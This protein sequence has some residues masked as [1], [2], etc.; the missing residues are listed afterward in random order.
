ML[1]CRII[2]GRRLVHSPCLSFRSVFLLLWRLTKQ[3][4]VGISGSG[5]CLARQLYCQAG[6]WSD[7]FLLCVSFAMLPGKFFVGQLL[8]AV[9]T[10]QSAAFPSGSDNPNR[11]VTLSPLFYDELDFWRW[12]VDKGFTTMVLCQIGFS[13]VWKCGRIRCM[14][15]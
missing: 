10:P 9:G 15:L 2:I 5:P 12:L 6:V 8:A 3:V 11:R 4:G 13:S 7:G 1:I 14:R